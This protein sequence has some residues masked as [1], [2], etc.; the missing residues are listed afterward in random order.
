[1][2]ISVQ[3]TQTNSLR[4]NL[5]PILQPQMKRRRELKLT[6]SAIGLLILASL[7]AFTAAC[8]KSTSPGKRYEFRGRVVSVDKT[9]HTAIIAHE[10]IKDFMPAMTMEFRIKD[11]W[12]L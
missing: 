6:R 3:R 10:D 11:D 7:F 4:Y 1:M 12:A 8:R 2:V 5:P 9:N